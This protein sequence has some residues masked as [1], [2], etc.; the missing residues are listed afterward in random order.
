MERTIKLTI[1]IGEPNEDTPSGEEIAAQLLQDF[2]EVLDPG[3]TVKITCDN[4]YEE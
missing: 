4:E 3:Q 1:V 2:G